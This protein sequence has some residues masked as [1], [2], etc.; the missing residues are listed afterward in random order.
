MSKQEREGI[1]IS[2][3]S[4]GNPVRMEFNPRHF[5]FTALREIIR[6]QIYSPDTFS[7]EII[8]VIRD[9]NHT[10]EASIILTADTLAAARGLR[11]RGRRDFVSTYAMC[12][13]DANVVVIQKKSN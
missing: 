1:S 7:L 13:Y 9:A 10:R 2:T 5:S 12:A 6:Y 8:R 3:N 11:S 4:E